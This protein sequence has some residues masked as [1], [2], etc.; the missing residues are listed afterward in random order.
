MVTKTR[1]KFRKGL[2]LMAMAAL[3]ILSLIGG[4]TLASAAPLT[5]AGSNPVLVTVSDTNGAP[6][7]GLIV[8]VFSGT[9]YM[10]ISGVTDGSGQVTF[11]LATNTYNFRADLN[12]T[13]F[14]SGG[15]SGVN[16]C[17]ISTGCTADSVTV[18]SPVLVTVQDTNSAAQAGLSVYAFSGMTYTG[19]SGVTDGSGQA[20]FTLV[21]GDYNFRADLNGTQFFSGGVS[22]VNTCNIPSSGLD[23]TADSVTV[24]IPVVVT[25]QDTGSNPQAGVSVYA[26][27]GTTYSGKSGVTDVN[28]QVSLTLLPGDYNFRADFNGTQFFSGTTPGNNTCT[29]PGCTVDSVTV[30]S[31]VDVFVA[32]TNGTGQ[33]GLNV[34][35]FSGTA[36]T[37]KSGVTEGTGHVSFT[38]TPSDYNFRA[39]LNGTQFF[40]GGASGVDTCTIPGCTTD[41]VTVSTPITVTVQDSNGPLEGVN[42]YAFSGTIYASMTGITDVNGQV[43]FTLLPGSYNFRADLNGYQF[44]SGGAAGSDTCT[45]PSSGVDCTADTVNVPLFDTVAVTVSDGALGVPNRV[46][47]LFDNAGPTYLGRSSTTNASGVAMFNLPEGNYVFRTDLAGSQYWSTPVCPVIGCTAATILV[48]ASAVPPTVL[49]ANTCSLSGSVRTCDLWAKTGSV[50][51]PDGATV[52]IWGYSDT[53]VGDAQLPGPMI[54]VN[55]GE[56]VIINLT[57]ELP[58]T[59]GILFQ[60]QE[61]IPDMV[62][63]AANGGTTQYTF[64]TNNPGTFLYEAGL[65]PSSQYQAAM[66]LYGAL[67]VRPSTP[68]LAYNSG[69]TAFQQEALVMLSEIDPA[70]NNSANPAAFDMRDYVPQYYLI[71]GKSYPDT[72]PIPMRAGDQV[73]LRYAN[74]G[75]QYH[76]M[77]LAGMFEAVIGNDGHPLQYFYRMVAETISPGQTLDAIASVP[78]ATTQG[79][80][81]ALYDGNLMLHNNGEQGFGGMMTFLEYSAAPGTTGD[82]TGPSTSDIVLTPNPTKGS[83]DVTIAALINDVNSGNS[84][85]AAAEYYIDSTSGVAT[86]M[87]GA[88]ASPTEA[89]NG[90]ILAADLSTLSSGEHTVYV[91]GQDSA[92]NWGPF[93]FAILNL[94]KTGPATTGITLL[95]N[96]SD[97]LSDVALHAT[98]ND[99]NSGGLNVAMGEFFIGG[100]PGEG[101][102]TSIAPNLAASVVSLDTV[103]PSASIPMA[104]GV[105]TLSV[106]SQDALGNWGLAA[107]SDLLVDTTGPS[108][109]NVSAMPNPN[110]GTLGINTNMP[111]VRVTAVLYDPQSN[112]VQSIIT[113]GEGFIDAIGAD[114]TGF[115]L[116]PSDGLFDAN[117]ENGFSDIP[118]PTIAFL[119]EGTHIIYI[120]GRD[121]AGNW[122]SVFNSVDLIIDKTAP[123]IGSVNVSPNPTAG[124]VNVT[125]NATANDTVGPI[126]QAEWFVGAD[127]G[128]GNGN[129][130]S[131][132]PAWTAVANINVST[133]ADGDYTLNVRVRDAA[134]NWSFVSSTVFTVFTPPPAFAGIS[135]S[136]AGNNALSGVGGTADNADIYNSDGIAFSRTWDAA[137]DGLPGGANVDGLVMIDANHF[138]LSFA[139]D[140]AVPGLGTVQD[141]DIVEYNAGVWSVYFDGTANGLT[142]NNQDI[143]AFSIVGGTLYFSTVGNTNPPGVGGTADDADVYS[144]NGTIF[145]RV[146]DA[147]VNGLPGNADIDGL[148]IVDAAHFYASFLATNTTVPGLGAVADVNVIYNDAGTWSV[149]F[150]GVTQGLT[151]GSGQDLDAFD[152]P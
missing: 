38:L 15:A 126:S 58:Q 143:D 128:P 141:E 55:E 54:I 150:D 66:G 79:S 37:G 102:G 76:S 73:L 112:G 151:A 116:L 29:V 12:G 100:D 111:A 123:T 43:S 86:G 59:S 49:P 6:Q 42:V 131:L 133:W 28:G 45:I 105:Y 121:A 132:V 135:F 67:I 101:N 36:Y 83:V 138:Y 142:A 136:T 11:N 32:D 20:S 134:G 114:G 47:Y 148:T 106:R 78:A 92:G 56:T 46:V 60:G 7:Q 96:P 10:G 64:V 63:A 103:I 81:F 90:V 97:G 26:F 23:C 117:M 13:Q 98:G 139:G 34:Y 108:T 70:L 4:V 41:S 17:D 140:T 75:Q 130:M 110:N 137:A 72:T 1:N 109:S 115:S 44:F 39:D 48:P 85:I 24:T 18:T 113:A 94:D 122:G 61:M 149:F 147:S 82:T 62:G 71:N 124:A 53:A 33:A 30:T 104:E 107:T 2:W 5:Q 74:A 16:S 87:L 125:L 31:A 95:P 21:P 52:P 40:S 80:K 9:T 22:G 88:F 8:Y 144:W 50:M 77:S 14:F 27:S 120:H 91:H 99:S 152:I 127:P 25:V 68:G 19:K 145:S 118:L 3:L 51:M 69:T 129:A 57:N 93:S 89:V 65:L 119:S 84:D 35:A 146:W